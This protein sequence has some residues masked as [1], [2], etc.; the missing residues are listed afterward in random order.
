[1]SKTILNVPSQRTTPVA[2]NSL[3]LFGH[4][5]FDNSITGAVG[6]YVTRQIVNDDYMFGNIFAYSLGLD[7][8]RVRNH[9][10]AGNSLI[11][12][13]RS[14]GGFAKVLSEMVGPPMQIGP[15]MRGQVSCPLFC[16]GI[17]DIG[18]NTAANQSL[19]RTTAQNCYTALISKARASAIYL[20][21]NT[22]QWAL[23]TN[24]TASAHGAGT[25]DDWTSGH[26]VQCTAVDSGGTSTATFTIPIGYRG[27]PIFFN[28]V[29]LSTGT[30]VVTFGGTVTGTTGIVGSTLTLGGATLSAEC[31]RGVRFTSTANGLSPA[32]AGQTISV[33]VTSITSATFYL[34]GAW[35]ESFKPGPVLICNVARLPCRTYSYQFGDGVTTGVNTSFTSAT[36]L[37]NATAGGGNWFNDT[38]STLTELDSQG[39]FNSGLTVSSVTNATTIVL[40]GNANLAATSI[41]YQIARTG[42]GYLGYYTTNTDFTSAT[43]ANHAAADNDVIAWNTMLATVV[44][45]FDSMVQIVDI[46]TA[47]GGGDQLANIPSNVYSLFNDG[48]HPNILGADKC[49][50]AC[51]AAAAACT[52]APDLQPIG[53][54]EVAS[55][56]AYYNGPDRRI[57]NSGSI[58]LPE[59]HF[60]WNSTTAPF[61]NGP[62]AYT[63]VAGQVFAYPFFISEHT[64]FWG[65]CYLYQIN[66][67]ATAG[68]NIRFGIYDDPGFLGYPQTLRYE[69]TSGGAI[70]LGT[71]SGVKNPASFIPIV[72][73]YGL[74]WIVLK[75]DS[76]GTTAS[77][78]TSIVGP[79]KYM[80]N[81]STAGGAGATTGI[82]GPIAWQLTGVAAGALPTI[83][84]TGAGLVSVAP[85]FGVGL[86][87][88]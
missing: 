40:S 56:G 38:G 68:S 7:R 43:P 25:P 78:L 53:N 33:R 65:Q 11:A 5:Y 22:T 55:S 62:T 27:E 29:G 76:L 87:L 36:A 88:Q 41:K 14:L 61:T 13:G 37:F 31:C 19:V 86:T 51:F 49:A 64:V 81:F 63:C 12:P 18:N 16:Y 80:P 17:N 34:D 4:S 30:L 69:P 74:Y 52:E 45:Q 9:A 8:S 42:N 82:Y 75:I 46:D 10:V 67:P 47:L 57:I 6:T 32:N 48:L 77:Q 72:A 58:Y 66:A 50:Q 73:H 39:A 15:F 2:I 60:Q 21:A 20:A 79:N 71:T 44:A 26:A 28:M 59:Y 24:F 70:A 54:L 84:P 35:I 23:G 1:M 83:F 85:A 3:D